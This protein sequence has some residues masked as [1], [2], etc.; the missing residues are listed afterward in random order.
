MKMK[1]LQEC[2][3][4]DI[5]F[6]EEKNYKSVMSSAFQETKRIIKCKN[7]GLVQAK[8]F[9]SPN[10]IYE[11]SFFNDE[12]VGYT[13]YEASRLPFVRRFT[14]E[15]N[16]IEKITKTRGKAKLLDI[17]AA[18]GIMLEVSGLYGYEAVGI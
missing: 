2:N 13:D 1:K 15:L 10:E 4:C 9:G 5:T 8:F 16:A 17:G 6:C 3:F 11:E 18:T 14:R 12:K 7:C